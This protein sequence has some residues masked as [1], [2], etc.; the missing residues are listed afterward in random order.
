MHGYGA[1]MN[2]GLDAATGTYVGILESDDYVCEHAWE[3]LYAL[4]TKSNL[5]IVKGCYSYSFPRLK[6]R[7][8]TQSPRLIDIA[9]HGFLKFPSTPSSHQRTD[10]RCFWMN[11]SI[12]TGIY[13]RDFLLKNNIRFNETPGASYQDT[14]FA[15]KVWVS[16]ERAMATETPVIH[17]RLDS[18][19]SSSNSRAKVFAVCDEMDE[20]EEYLD[21]R[22]SDGLFYHIL[23]ALRYKTYLWN[24]GRVSAA[25][26]LSFLD[27]MRGDF[28]RDIELNRFDAH[29]FDDASREEYLAIAGVDEQLF[30]FRSFPGSANP[31]RAYPAER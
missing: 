29:L 27:R 1:A 5:D 20:C 15:F 9:P 22:N 28:L 6:S 26:K 7:S 2:D 16:A 23:C 17:Y 3:K 13:K 21:R 31:Y 18:A 30:R 12:W 25:L 19:F 14:S 4:A 24:I 11:P 10:P 8:S